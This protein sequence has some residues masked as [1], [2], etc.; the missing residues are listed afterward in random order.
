MAGHFCSVS[1]IDFDGMQVV[2]I[3]KDL[4]VLSPYAQGN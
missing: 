3:K 1:V 4:H 2:E